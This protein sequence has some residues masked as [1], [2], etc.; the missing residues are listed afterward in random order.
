MHAAQ[1]QKAMAPKVQPQGA[2]AKPVSK[3]IAHREGKRKRDDAALKGRQA[4]STKKTKTVDDAPPRK[5]RA[6]AA[7]SSQVS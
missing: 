2:K 5:K 4:P 1:R 3:D 7:S 6:A